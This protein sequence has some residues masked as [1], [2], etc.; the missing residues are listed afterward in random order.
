MSEVLC[1]LQR[2]L[3]IGSLLL[4]RGMTVPVVHVQASDNRVQFEHQILCHPLLAPW[5]KK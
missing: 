2:S 1:S 5:V 3:L 4:D